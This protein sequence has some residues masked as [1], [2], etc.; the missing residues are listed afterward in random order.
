MTKRVLYII[1][2]AAGPTQY[3]DVGVRQAQARG[4]D[5]CLVLTPSAAAWW[6]PRMAELEKLTGHPVRSRYKLPW[7]KDALAKADAMLF[8]PLS[9]TSLNKWGGGISDTLAIGLIS[10]GVHMGV[11]ALVMSYFNQAQGAQPAVAR[12]IAGL[13]SRVFKALG[14]LA[15]AGE[16]ISVSSVA[17]ATG[18][19]VHRSLIHRHGDLHAADI[20]RAGQP[21][22]DTTTGT[23]VSR[24]S[25]LADISNLTA[26]NGRL[27]AHV[28]RLE[29]HL[30]E[31][32]GQTAWEVSAS[33]DIKTLTRRTTEL[34]HSRSSTAAAN[35]RNGTRTSKPHAPRTGNS[36]PR[37]TVV[38][39]E[40]PAS[41]KASCCGGGR[42]S[43]PCV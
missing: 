26:R 36:W 16:E 3:I 30:S 24:K 1:A 35:S 40:N 14:Q 19:H 43:R 20:A 13:R 5:T 34:E 17:R 22:P 25:L 32:L 15:S 7:E 18:V 6:E 28:T 8:A 10:E 9:C 41:R 29:R 2:C 12:S 33:A 37:S 11:P 27:A 42:C 4:W 31:A 38:R 23:Q 21:P 39:P